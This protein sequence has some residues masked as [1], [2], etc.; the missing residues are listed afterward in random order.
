MSA[1]YCLSCSFR[2]C[3]GPDSDFIYQFIFFFNPTYVADFSALV[4]I[5]RLLLEFVGDSGA[6]SSLSSHIFLDCLLIKILHRWYNCVEMINWL[7]L[8]I[9]IFT[10]CMPSCHCMNFQ[11]LY[12]P[13]LWSFALIFFYSSIVTWNHCIHDNIWHP[14]AYILCQLDVTSSLIWMRTMCGSF[15]G[16]CSHWCYLKV[17]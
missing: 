3:F 1:S 10:Y 17:C 13:D 2:Q 9:V 14:R 5:C 4:E 11:N 12:T 6:F 7:W 8:L 15:L 16:I